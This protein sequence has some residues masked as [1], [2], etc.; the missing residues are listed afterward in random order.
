MKENIR[1]AIRLRPVP[2]DDK[3]GRDS[4]IEFVSKNELK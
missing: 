4:T 2:D 1:V 3:D